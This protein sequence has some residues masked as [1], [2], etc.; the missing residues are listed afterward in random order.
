MDSA[1][2]TYYFVTKFFFIIYH[3]ISPQLDVQLMFIL[4]TSD[5]SLYDFSDLKSKFL[6]NH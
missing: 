1:F 3:Y 2:R 6:T 5:I 4:F